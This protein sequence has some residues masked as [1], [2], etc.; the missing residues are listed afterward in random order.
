MVKKFLVDYNREGESIKDKALVGVYG[1]CGVKIFR[2][3]ALMCRAA[4][5]IRYTTDFNWVMSIV[6]NVFVVNGTI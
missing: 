1:D 4:T 2:F 6:K 5:T 3:A